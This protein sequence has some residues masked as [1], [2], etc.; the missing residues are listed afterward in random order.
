M[1]EWSTRDLRYIDIKTGTRLHRVH[2]EQFGATEFNPRFGNARFS[3]IKRANGTDFNCALMESVFHEV[4]YL[5]GPKFMPKSV[6]EEK[7]HSALVLLKP[8]RLLDL[9]AVSL[10]SMGLRRSEL[11]ETESDAYPDTRRRAEQFHAAAPQAQGLRWVS[12]QD[13]RKRAMVLFG[14]R[15]PKN[16]FKAVSTRPLTDTSALLSILKLAEHIGVDFFEG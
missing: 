13:D 9:S 3:P 6:L 4:P 16:T 15:I 12:R 1:A 7:V 8:I 10:R 14:D 11:I 2:P 5:P